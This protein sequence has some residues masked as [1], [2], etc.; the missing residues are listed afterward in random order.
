[1]TYAEYIMY[2]CIDIVIYVHM[3]VENEDVQQD[4][5]GSQG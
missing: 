5:C 3:G 1:M 2:A 4:G